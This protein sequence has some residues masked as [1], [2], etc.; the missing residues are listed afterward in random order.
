MRTIA[1]IRWG[2]LIGEILIGAALAI[3]LLAVM[4]G[5]VLQES[6]KITPPTAEELAEDPSLVIYT[7]GYGK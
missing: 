4:A 7:E 2:R 3:G 5:A 6:F 1:R